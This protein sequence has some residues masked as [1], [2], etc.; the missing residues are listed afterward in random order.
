MSFIKAYFVAM[1]G[2]GV[3]WRLSSLSKTKSKYKYNA[4]GVS[5]VQCCPLP[6]GLL[7]FA[8]L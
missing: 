6:N 1:I 3:G 7:S 5:F 4:M 2:D 8:S